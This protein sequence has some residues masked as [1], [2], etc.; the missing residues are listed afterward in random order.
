MLFRSEFPKNANGHTGNLG[1]G[2]VFLESDPD[3]VSNLELAQRYIAD[4][5]GVAIPV[6]PLYAGGIRNDGYGVYDNMLNKEVFLWLLCAPELC[7]CLDLFYNDDTPGALAYWYML[8]NRGYRIG[9]AATSDAALDLGRSPGSGRGATFV[10][11]KQL[12]EQELIAGFR[13]RRTMVSWHGG[14]LLMSIGDAMPGDIAEP[15]P[16]PRR[17]KFEIWYRPGAD[18]RIALIRNGEL[19]AGYER[20][21]PE[22]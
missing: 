4:R 1:V 6:H 18:V 8:L 16:E 17:L 2:P 5:D 13:R 15:G 11:M 10:F 7:P 22:S 19:R 12:N 20:K 14:V 9:C 3:R 21:L